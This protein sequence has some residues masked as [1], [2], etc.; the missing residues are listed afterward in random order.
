MKSQHRILFFFFGQTLHAVEPTGTTLP[1]G[2]AFPKPGFTNN[3]P[4]KS[5]QT[6]SR[7]PENEP[8]T[9]DW[10]GA[11]FDWKGNGTRVVKDCQILKD[12]IKVRLFKL[13]NKSE[14][15]N[16]ADLRIENEWM[17]TWHNKNG[18]EN[19]VITFE[20]TFQNLESLVQNSRG[21]VVFQA[22]VENPPRDFTTLF[23]LDTTKCSSIKNAS[24]IGR[25]IQI[26]IG[27]GCL[28][29]FIA[30]IVAIVCHLKR[31][32]EG[33]AKS[34]ESENFDENPDYG[35][36]SRGWFGEGNYG[37]GDKVYVTD[38]NDYYTSG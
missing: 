12:E 27:V 5:N 31:V 15:I 8:E 38:T 37:D 4:Q 30:A 6:I 32:R 13:T 34:A 17:K 1:L 11:D 10:C 23:F 9:E 24:V 16:F 3:Y 25:E 26:A 29:V 22:R 21:A 35:T 2:I 36:Y 18:G 20:N 14:C 28:V 7:Q 33:K 19:K